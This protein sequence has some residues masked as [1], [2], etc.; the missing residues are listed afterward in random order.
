ME[1]NARRE[2]ANN[3]PSFLDGLQNQQAQERSKYN[4]ID[5]VDKGVLNRIDTAQRST[6]NI[7][8]A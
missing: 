2:I 5:A 3:K 7:G 6:S 1:F 8:L 4:Y